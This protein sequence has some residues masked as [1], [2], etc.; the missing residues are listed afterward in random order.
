MLKAEVV[1]SKA[2]ISEYMMRT[3]QKR[4]A[5]D[6]DEEKSVLGI[7]YVALV[8]KGVTCNSCESNI[9]NQV[10]HHATL[11]ERVAVLDGAFLCVELLDTA[12]DCQRKPDQDR[13]VDELLSTLVHSVG[14]HEAADA[15][16]YSQECEQKW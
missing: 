16:E 9:A 5:E 14:S 6:R 10:Q 11:H 15:G 4:R 3:Q 13:K 1:L 7:Q 2:A 12:H 8:R